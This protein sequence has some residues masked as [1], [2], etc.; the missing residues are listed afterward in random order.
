MALAHNLRLAS[1]LF[2][3]LYVIGCGKAGFSV[4]GKLEDNGKPLT[5]SD[6]GMVNMNL[7]PV[8]DKSGASVFPADVSKDG[9]F[10][11]RPRGD[12]S[13][14]TSGKYRVSIEIVDPYPGKDKLN[15]KFS[16]AK[17]PIV[18]EIN[19][20]ANLTIDIAKDQ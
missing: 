19:G 4:T 3:C 7:V 9:T 13:L 12:G 17:S 15:G 6:K 20:S 8:E 11:V 1:F 2:M 5:V 16:G 18:R 14:P 10:T